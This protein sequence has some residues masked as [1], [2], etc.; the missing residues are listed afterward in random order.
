MKPK[1]LKLLIP[2]LLAFIL[3]F[4]ASGSLTDLQN[5]QRNAAGRMTT[6]RDALA[7]ARRQGNELLAEMLELDVE[8]EDI[9]DQYDAAF[10][11]LQETIALLEATQT[12]LDEANVLR[13]IQYEAYRESVRF[14]HER[15]TAG[16]LEIL[17]RSRSFTDIVRNIEYINRIVTHDANI[18]DELIETERVITESLAVIRTNMARQTILESQLRAK[19]D[20]LETL[21]S[22]KDAQMARIEADT[23]RHEQMVRD[24]EAESNRL[25]DLIRQ[26]EAEA[27]RQEALRR[28]Q[29]QQQQQQT[30]A[31]LSGVFNWPVQGRS[32]ISSPFGT[33][34][35]PINRRSEH[36]TGIDIPAPAGTHILA[37]ESGTVILSGWNGGFGNTVIISHGNGVSTLYAHNSRNHVTVGQTVRRGQHIANVGSTGFST[38]NHLHFEV[39]IDGVP[40][41]PMSYFSR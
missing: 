5:Q 18:V 3:T 19:L 8:I 29:Q 40:T 21:R 6:A 35:N 31:N 38:G 23:R 28:Q 34:I 25:G 15:G 22:E 2:L 7:E 10:E 27:A 13:E 4:T 41:N 30:T 24:L 14:L 11:E 37:A 36:H 17:F 12:R 9:S 16:Y 1:Y 26:A 33:R 20:E 39:R 32:T